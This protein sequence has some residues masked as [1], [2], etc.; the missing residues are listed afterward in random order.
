ML[1]DTRKLAAPG[2]EAGAHK[3]STGSH[4]WVSGY[5]FKENEPQLGKELAETV[6]AALARPDADKALAGLNG[7]F[8]AI[9]VSAARDRLDV[10]SDRFGS[11]PLYHAMDN[12]ALLI[13]EDFW[14]ICDSLPKPSMSIEAAVELITFEYVLGE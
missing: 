5:C 7:S 10:V 6:S 14:A 12:G 2:W 4:A 11:R 9:L 1:I 8:W 3:L 13:D